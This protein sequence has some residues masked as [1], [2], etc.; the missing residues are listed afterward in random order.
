M[1]CWTS[2]LRK[3]RRFA[4]LPP[5]DRRTLLAAALLLRLVTVARRMMSFKRLLRRIDRLMRL[6][7]T[8]AAGDVAEA[9]RIAR[10]VGIAAAHGPK[11]A[12]CLD[13]ALV[14]WGLLRRQGMN[15]ELCLGARK[16]NGKFEAH[17]WVEYLGVVIND[18]DDVR[19]QFAVFDRP[20]ER[21][22]P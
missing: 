12:T 9:L 11:R 6:R 1:A 22:T 14:L 20:E 19:D 16:V 5:R 13:R 7:Q 21:L 18:T 8:D 3:R 15:A 2:A 17:T 4:A 10:L